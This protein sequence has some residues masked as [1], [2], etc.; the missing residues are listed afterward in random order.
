MKTTWIIAN[1]KSHKT[2]E[3]ALE[4]VSIVGPKV[5]R[6]NEN[7]KVVVCPTF[8]A[9]EEVKK[10][11]QVGGFAILVGAQDL[12]AYEEGAHTGEEP[13][14]TLKQLV[15]LAILGHSERR[16][17]LGETDEMVGQKVDQSVANGILP[18]VC[19]QSKD[20]PVPKGCNLVAYEPI[21]AIG[22]GKPDTPVDANEVASV[23]KQR[24]GTDLTVLYGGS[25]NAEN[26]K[27]FLKQD[28][29]NGVLVGKASLD[30]TEFVNIIQE[31]VIN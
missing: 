22:T 27:A 29:I 15:S 6:G 8:V 11:I 5:P 25:V 20:T 30:A 23:L 17:Q 9:I 19:V 3:E 28:H 1:W 18:L 14:Q 10:A 31:S 26:V 2:I 7:I 21:F 16:E 12:S 4:W 13:A 24:S